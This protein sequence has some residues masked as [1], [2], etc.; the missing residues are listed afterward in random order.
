MLG[1]ETRSRLGKQMSR[2]KRYR[3]S[4]RNRMRRKSATAKLKLLQHELLSYMGETLLHIQAA[5]R[6]L[7]FCI[8]YFFP[9]DKFKTIEDVEAQA[10]AD[11]KKALGQLLVLMRKRIEV[12]KLFDR[13]LEQFVE[14]RNALAHRFLGIQG[15]SIRNVEGIRN[16]AK[17]LDGLR[18]QAIYVHKTMQGLMNAI[19]GEKPVGEEDEDYMKLAK[20]IFFGGK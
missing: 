9:D 3:I 15:I 6:Q 20:L 11:R 5:E 7:Q 18:A 4:R 12:N 14:D 19:L 16:A 10:E 1:C 17:F 13:E 2:R 8:S